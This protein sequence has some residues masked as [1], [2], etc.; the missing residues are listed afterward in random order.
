MKTLL[1]SRLVL[2]AALLVV[3][4][5]VTYA[6]KDFLN[7]P[8]QG[9]LDANSLATKDGVEGS[10]LAAY[11]SL[12]CNNAT[13][14]NWGC[15]ASNWAFASIT[16][17]DAYK[18]STFA[19]Q[20]QAQNL[21]LY[22]WI[23][24]QAQDYLDNKWAAM[25]E[26][27]VRANATIRGLEKV[28]ETKPG[29]ISHADSMG[30]RGEAL[31]LRAH[32]HFELWRMWGNV[33]YYYETDQDFRKPNDTDPVRGADSVA[34]KILADLDAAIKL[35]GP[36]PRFGEKGRASA[37]TA[38]AYKGRVLAYMH[39]Y[40]Q[41]IAVFDS[42]ITQGVYA[43]ETSYDRVWTGFHA[44]SN[45]PETILAYQASV[46][47]GEPSGNNSN[48]GERLNLPYAGSP[49][50]C[51]GFHQPSQNLA[52][53]FAVDPVRGLPKAFT[54]SA[55]WN[56]RDSTWVASKTDTLD[57][58]ID[59]TIGRD[60]VPYKDWG[61]HDTLW[62]RLIANGGR[63]SAK[64]NAQE[65]ASGAVSKVGW[66]PE[67]ENAVHIHIFR[68]ADLL[69]LDAEAKIETGDL[70]G[71]LALVNQVRARAGQ[72][73]QGCGDG[74]T[75]AALVARYPQCANDNRI[76]VPIADSSIGWATYKV[77]QYTIA[78]WPTAARARAAV[79]IERRLELAMEGQRFFDLR[80][81]GGAYASQTMATFLA[82]EKTRIPYKATQIPYATPL[83]DLYP[84]PVAEI[85]LSIVGGQKRLTQNPGW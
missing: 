53:F 75:D 59:W 24:D 54:D 61:M 46:N 83:N 45:G 67:Q 9:A 11:R 55:N 48:Y 2:G 39:Q 84:I 73:A 5:I 81:Y 1:R 72:T 85:D 10:L 51:C 69:L 35:L 56:N 38:R 25:Y 22:N 50:K 36:T 70:P 66:Q 64:K 65:K 31:F 3:I 28:S 44:F 78:D 43:L 30:I 23:G 58:R 20:Y 40:P 49:F 42:V 76:A 15:A 19:D 16:S 12:D 52:N 63:Y 4:G 62:I 80:R 29:E 7:T 47:D 6:C 37:W 33:P 26:G 57:P 13:N 68:Y 21:E 14:G 32:Y 17:E 71:A 27:V 60:S 74:A 82:K 79:R 34:Q 8:T 41:A 18:G 77:G